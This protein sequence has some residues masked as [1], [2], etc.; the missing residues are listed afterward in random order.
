MCI[1]DRTKPEVKRLFEECG[2]ENEKL[3]T[4]DQTYEAIAGENASL[5]A[6]NIT[7]TRRTET[8]SYTHLVVISSLS[9]HVI[10]YLSVFC[11]R[12]SRICLLYTSRCV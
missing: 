11:T 8:V 1:R 10:L 2:V 3:E 4:F 7:N 6:A 5:M 9:D 12:L